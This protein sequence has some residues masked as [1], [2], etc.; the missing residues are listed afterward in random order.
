MYYQSDSEQENVGTL[1]PISGNYGNIQPKKIPVGTVADKV[2][3][4]GSNAIEADV[5]SVF[6][7]RPTNAYDKWFY[8]TLTLTYTPV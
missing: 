7:S 3:V 4:A 5:R 6:D 8:S 2:S 1:S